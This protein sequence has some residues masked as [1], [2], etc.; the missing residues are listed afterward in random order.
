[1]LRPKPPI[2]AYWLPALL[3]R[4]GMAE[5]SASS[6]A[7]CEAPAVDV[8]IIGAGAS[9]LVAASL[10]QDAGLSIAVL[11]ARERVGGRLLSTGGVD[12]GGSWIWQSDART[13]GLARRLGLETVQQSLAGDAFAQTAP[14]T[15]VQNYG[16]V[17]DRMAPCGPDALRFSGGYQAL[18]Y[19]LA[20]GLPAG[21][22]MLGR[23]VVTLAAAE[24]SSSVLL[25]HVGTM[26]TGP[27][28]LTAKRVIVAIPSG[29]AGSSLAFNPPLPEQRRRKMASTSTWC[30][31]WCKVVAHF[32]APF[33]RKTG[34]SGVV[35]TAGPFGIWWEGASGVAPE[36][37]VALV[38]LGFGEQACADGASSNH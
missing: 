14:G 7:A 29:L 3:L 10:L 5:L 1:M 16:N 22:V 4:A 24:D 35:Q 21:A 2:A 27:Q 9:G 28:T 20:A 18:A 11:D 12:L 13:L 38:G 32:S 25:T 31:D 6:E 37:A 30:G 19:K 17:G 36:G 23:R 33:W 8:A 15:R 26:D 34:A